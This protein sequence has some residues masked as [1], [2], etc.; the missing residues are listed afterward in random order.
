VGVIQ[1]R[2]TKATVADFMLA[3]S[4]VKKSK[5]AAVQGHWNYLQ[6]LPQGHQVEAGG[7]P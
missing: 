3:N 7:G 2:I 6:T 4:I 1:S 5:D